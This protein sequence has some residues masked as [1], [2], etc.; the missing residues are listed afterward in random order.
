[1]SGSWEPRHLGRHRMV[2]NVVVH[3]I[4]HLDPFPTVAGTATLTPVIPP[5]LVVLVVWSAAVQIATGAGR[6]DRGVCIVGRYGVEYLVKIVGII[7]D[8]AGRPLG[9]RYLV[10]HGRED[11]INHI[12]LAGTSVD[13]TGSRTH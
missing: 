3:T 2:G 7:H 11:G 10:T 12:L 1:M 6:P 13:N 4:L 9:D 5:T 8:D